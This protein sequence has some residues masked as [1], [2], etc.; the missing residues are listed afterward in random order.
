MRPSPLLSRVV[1]LL[2]VRLLNHARVRRLPLGIFLF[3]TL[4]SGACT[5]AVV[6]STPKTPSAGEMAEFWIDPGATPRD[7]FNGV[8]GSGPKPTV[9]GRYEVLKRDTVG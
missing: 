3:A 5:P 9:D 6:R 1:E 2:A 4:L 7:L 8:G